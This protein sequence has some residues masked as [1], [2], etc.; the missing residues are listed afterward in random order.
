M[1]NYCIKE[2]RKP[3]KSGQRCVTAVYGDGPVLEYEVITQETCKVQLVGDPFYLQVNRL[4]VQEHWQCV[5]CAAVLSG[6][7]FQCIHAISPLA[8]S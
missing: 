7:V 5:L 6:G 1:Y 4:R 3:C 8:L 2:L